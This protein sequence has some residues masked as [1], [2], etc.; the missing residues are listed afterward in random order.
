MV[1]LSERDQRML[2]GALG[3]AA[4]LAMSTIVRMADILGASELQDITQA[5]IDGCGLMS[6]SGLEFAERLARLGAR[7]SV[8]TTLNMI[9]LDLQNWKK[10]GVPAEFAGKAIRMADAYLSMGCIPTFTCAP[11][12]GYLTPHFG[13]QIAWGE[14]NAIAYANS[15]LG[16]RTERYADFMDICAAIAG[17]VPKYGLHLQENRRGQILFR[18]VRFE[19]DDFTDERIYPALGHLIG[20]IVQD[21]IPVIE[22]LAT[23]VT[24][25]QFK[26]FGAAAASSGAVGLF[27][28]VGLTPEARTV[29]EAFQGSAPEEVIEVTP[30]VLQAAL[31]DLST[32]QKDEVKLDGVLFGCPHFSYDEFR[33]LTQAIEALGQPRYPDVRMIILTSQMSDALLSRGGLKPMLDHFGAEIVIDSCVFHS[34]IV[35]S[36]AKV[37]MTNS[38]KA[39]YYSPGELEVGVA[40]GSLEDCVR[41]ATLGY[42]EREVR[43]WQSR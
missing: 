21:K 37:I 25:D 34:P 10:Q 8:P 36:G 29:A 30:A 1:Q 2:D 31:A 11:Y 4:R 9:P 6:D 35:T 26:A 7:V 23:R 18:L 33:R 41:S 5:H 40:F 27:H 42:V 13:Q 3:E 14:S 43:P 38:G 39:S 32:V 16:A 15:V 17:R 22:G 12:Q 28:M 24:S 20:R 19:P